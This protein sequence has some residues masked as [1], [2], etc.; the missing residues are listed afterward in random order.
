[1]ISILCVGDRNGPLKKYINILRQSSN[2]SLDFC[3]TPDEAIETLKG[4]SY[5]LI[6]SA[7]HLQG[8][9]G[10]ELLHHVREYYGDLPFVLYTGQEKED[11]AKDALSYGADFCLTDFIDLKLEHTRLIHVISRL[12]EVRESRRALQESIAHLYHAEY[13]AGLGHFEYHLGSGKISASPGAR[14]IFGC[15]EEDIA[16]HD[17]RSL[18]LIKDQNRFDNALDD[19]IHRKHSYNG[20]FKIRRPDNHSLIDVHIIAEYDPAAQ[21][22]FGIIQDITGRKK[23]ERALRLSESKFRML[24]ENINDVIFSVNTKGQIIYFSPAGERLYGYTPGDLAG[25]FFLDVVYEE[26]RPFVLKR[27]E[28]LEK[29]VLSPLEWRLIKKD[30][31]ISWVR[32]STRPVSDTGGNV[33]YFGVMTDITR[34]KEAAAALIES[35]EKYRSLVSYSLE[36]IIILDFE[37]NLLFANVAALNLVGARDLSQL[38]GIN[39]IDFIAP[40][41]REQVIRDLERVRKGDDAFHAEYEICTIHGERIWV[42]CVGKLIRYEG[43]DADLLS[44]RDVTEQKK[45]AEELRASEERFRSFVEDAYDI[46]YSLTPDGIFTYISPNWG[47]VLGHT[48]MEIIGTSYTT[49]VHPDDIPATRRFLETCIRTGQKSG[50]IEYRVRHKDGSWKWHV[51]SG[52]PV[53]NPDGTPKAFLGIAHDITERKKS[54]EALRQANRQLTLLSSVTRHDILNQIMTIFAYLDMIKEKAHDAHLDGIIRNI[55]QCTETIQSHIEF[56]RTY[57]GLGLHEP[58]WQILAGCI[59][60]VQLP[61]SVG[62]ILDIPDISLYADP[63]LPKVFLNLLDNSVR[64]GGSVT[65]IHISAEISGEDLFITIADDGVGIPSENKEKIFERGF[66]KNTGLGLFLV[67]EILSLPG[68]SIHEKGQEGHGAVFEIRVPNS[69]WRV[70]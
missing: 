53:M 40:G 32:T 2:I 10:I 27:F 63:M 24:V 49:I 21:V 58:Q 55:M 28:E 33:K 29:G 68:I 62:L 25:R 41:S 70:E 9:H 35:E 61:E 13:V 26:D 6:L 17:V 44:I 30:G 23:I 37:G 20:E 47:D 12:V 60:E 42:E 1:M 22:V 51:S 43:R 8:M 7:Y 69:G 15:T 4:S 54:E 59:H 65:S 67:R 18:L 19:L 56:T 31:S 64:H 52:T 46:V 38:T 14:A 34:E 45:A 16:F 66:G 11:V 39:V 5:D 3:P 48:A 36:G 57:E 50:G